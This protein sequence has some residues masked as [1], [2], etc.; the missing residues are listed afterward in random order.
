M[1]SV[2]TVKSKIQFESK[3][4][5]LSKRWHFVCFSLNS[6]NLEININGIQ[7][8]SYKFP[9]LSKF[10][11]SSNQIIK[12]SV[13]D[14]QKEDKNIVIF[15]NILPIISKESTESTENYLFFNF[16]KNGIYESAQMNID[17]VF[18]FSQF[19][20]QSFMKE[21][22][23]SQKVMFSDENIMIGCFDCLYSKALQQCGKNH[24]LCTQQEIYAFGFQIARIN[25]WNLINKKI[26]MY[27][28]MTDEMIESSEKRLG[29]CCLNSGLIN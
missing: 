3:A 6:L 15:K 9:N 4:R 19:M 8:S 10:A 26:W 22:A 25:G 13:I 29:L 16:G 20:S 12:N 23:I 24:H 2:Q 7:D 17:Q 11:K 28:Q 1:F 27:Y 5:L 14:L 21:L 18:I